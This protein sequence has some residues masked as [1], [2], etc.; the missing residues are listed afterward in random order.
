MKYHY[1]KHDGCVENLDNGYHMSESDAH[2]QIKDWNETWPVSK[3]CMDR[4]SLY[5]YGYA[6]LEIDTQMKI[7]FLDK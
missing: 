2:A 1:W 3:T 4:V 7:N 6:D 5:F